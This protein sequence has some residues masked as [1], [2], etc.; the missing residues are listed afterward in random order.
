MKRFEFKA[1][2]ATGGFLSTIKDVV[3]EPRFTSYINSGLGELTFRLPSSVFEFEESTIIAQNNMIKVE[4][5]DTDGSVDLYSGYIS[6]YTPT[7][8][9]GKQFVDVTCLGYVTQMERFMAEDASGNTTLTYNSYDPTDILKDVLDKFTAAGGTPDYDGSSTQDTSTTVSYEF[10]TYTVKEALDKVVGLSPAGWYYYVGA[11]NIVHFKGKSATA[12]HQLVLGKDIMIIVPEKSVENMTN[13]VYFTGGDVSGAPLYKKYS[14]ASSISEYG[15][16]AK[17]VVDTRVTDETTM[18]IMADS[19]LDGF[20]T[21]ET[22]TTLVVRD[23]NPDDGRGY[24]IESI[25]PGDTVQVLGYTDLNTN[26]WDLAVWDSDKWDYNLTQVT[27]TVQQIVKVHYEPNKVTLEI[28]S[29]LPNISHRVEDIKRNFDQYVTS[30][31][32]AAP[33]ED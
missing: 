26:L 3:D 12:D 14:R 7:L 1:Y 18:D 29:R 25:K 4:C 33:T 17:K 2:D 23:N 8:N 30:E 20:D 11:D 24:D 9:K 13:R 6:K 22:R 5:H 15:L 27:S 16:Y 28:S 31:N 32:P 21:P 10:N 19:L